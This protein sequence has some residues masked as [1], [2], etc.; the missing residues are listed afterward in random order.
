[1]QIER[2][3][4]MIYSPL[5]FVVLCPISSNTSARED[6]RLTGRAKIQLVLPYSEQFSNASYEE[7]QKLIDV[8]WIE[9]SLIIDYHQMACLWIRFLVV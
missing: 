1:M 2:T 4:S 3:D 9:T 6:I 8:G 5:P 7:K